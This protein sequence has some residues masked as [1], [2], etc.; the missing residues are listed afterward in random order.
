MAFF[1]C[2]LARF[3]LPYRVHPPDSVVPLASKIVIDSAHKFQEFS[4]VIPAQVANIDIERSVHPRR[5]LGQRLRKLILIVAGVN[6]GKNTFDV[7][8]EV[9]RFFFNACSQVFAVAEVEVL[10][11]IAFEDRVDT[12]CRCHD[13]IVRPLVVFEQFLILPLNLPVGSCEPGFESELIV[14]ENDCDLKIMA[15]E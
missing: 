14:I 15:F 12:L 5:S 3:F 9:K 2:S 10:S 13:A 4:Y 8:D 6:P 1:P 11:K 7:V